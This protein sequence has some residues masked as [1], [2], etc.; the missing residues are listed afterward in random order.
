MHKSSPRNDISADSIVLDFVPVPAALAI[1]HVW[2]MAHGHATHAKLARPSL[3]A[4]HVVSGQQM[5]VGLA[6]SQDIGRL[7]VYHVVAGEEF[8]LAHAEWDAEDELDEHQDQGGPDD[9]PSDDEER[10]DNPGFVLV[11]RRKLRVEWD[12]L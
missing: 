6:G 8:L 11:E 1:L 2:I 3:T 12:L 4:L 7:S 5:L 9:V 10:A